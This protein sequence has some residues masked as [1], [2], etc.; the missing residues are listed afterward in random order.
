M[1]KL[2]GFLYADGIFVALGAVYFIYLLLRRGNV[3]QFRDDAW[4]A[5]WKEKDQARLRAEE[6]RDRAILRAPLAELLS[7]EEDEEKTEPRLQGPAAAPA[8]GAARRGPRPGPASRPTGSTEFRAPNFN[9]A[10]HEVLGV[11]AGADETLI[12]RA[13]KYWIKRY[14]PDRVNHL[15]PGYVEQARRRSEQLNAAR[16]AMLRARKK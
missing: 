16:E 7:E 11:A 13:H 5:E 6:Q 10:P 15:G 9:G 1:N 2:Q 14:H 12:G 8:P 3:S 4:A